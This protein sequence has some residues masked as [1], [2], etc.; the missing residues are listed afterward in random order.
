MFERNLK[1][2]LSVIFINKIEGNFRNYLINFK[3]IIL[4]MFK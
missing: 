2:Y 3:V 1:N 4:F